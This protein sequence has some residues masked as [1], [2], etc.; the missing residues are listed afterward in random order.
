RAPLGLG[1]VL[2]VGH[3]LPDDGHRHERDGHWHEDQGL[4]RLLVSHAVGEDGEKQTEYQHQAR[5]KKQPQKVVPQHNQDATVGKE[6]R[7]VAQSHERAAMSVE[8]TS[9][10]SAD[11]GVV[12]DA[13]EDE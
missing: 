10:D 13:I 1:G 12:V 5:I 8:E 9:Y 3:E 11:L 6:P 7:E 4:D 2:V